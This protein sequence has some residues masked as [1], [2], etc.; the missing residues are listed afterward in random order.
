VNESAVFT[1]INQLLVHAASPEGTV[2]TEPGRNGAPKANILLVDDHPEKLLALE[3]V[4]S[5]LGENLVKARSGKDALRLILR[6]EFA[7]ILLD[8]TMPGMDGFETASL[9]RK[10]PRCENTPIIFVTAMSNNE[11]HVSK[12]Y[13]LGAV[14]YILAP[15]VPEVLR[16]KVSVFVELYKKTEQIRQQ[17]ERLR[18]IEEAEHK[19]Q[20][21]EAQSRLDAETK[22]NHFFTLS[23]D[24]LGIADFEGRLLQLNP[25]WEK[26]LGF[27]EDELKQRSGLDLVHPDDRASMLEQFELLK[28][29]ENCTYLEGRYVCKDGSFR[30]LGWTAAPF[31]ADRLIYIFAR[32]ITMRKRAEDQIRSL[33]AQLNKRLLEL[34][35]INRELEG[36]S[37]SIAHD[38]RAPLRAMLGFSEALLEDCATELPDCGQDYARRIITSARQMDCLIRDLLDYSRLSTAE[39]PL[40]PVNL[41][42]QIRAVLEHF[43][44]DIQEKKARIEPRSPLAS[45]V[46][47]PA[48][49]QQILC[50]LLS[51]A[52]KF[53]E[54]GRTPQVQIW[55]EHRGTMVRC[56]VADNG[57]GIAT[58]HQDRIFGVFERL[59]TTDR[60][61][62]TGI[63]LAIVRKAVERMGGS[64]GVESEPERGSRFWFEMPAA[65][66]S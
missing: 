48:T 29:G 3:S 57:I 60:Y 56:W 16:T 54:P 8:V 28:Q 30:W 17:G 15:I 31:P 53:T 6:Q 14:D 11:T 24:M 51:N 10:R 42:L 5:D 43:N 26:T 40:I 4:L 49:L 19:R 32:D 66:D 47:H 9:I 64:S 37:Y 34:T 12:G 35:A 38:L 18:R 23:L 46:A 50:N 45:V 44:G 63:G 55:T 61:P 59:H 41:D 52:L 39:L 13:S 20:L 62:G 65:S 33:N 58:E 36:F 22:R 21:A 7:V 2:A 25:S 27:S 1:D